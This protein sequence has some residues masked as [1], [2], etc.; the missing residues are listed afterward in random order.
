MRIF[1][2][3]VIF[4]LS[5]VKSQGQ[6]PG[7][8]QRGQDQLPFSVSGQIVDAETGAPLEYTTVSLHN[9]SDSSLVTGGITNE[10]GEFKISTR[11]GRFYLQ[12]QFISYRDKML[13][14]IHLN[15]NNPEVQLGNISLEPD[16]ETLSEVVVAG[17]KSQMLMKLDKRV[18][19]VGKDLS[20]AGGN[21]A[22]ILDNIP[23]V[24][25]DVDGNV[26]LR[27]SQNVRILVDGKPSGLVGIS[28]TDALR[29]LQGDLIERIE[30]ITNPSARY[31]AEGMAGIINIILKKDNREGLN[32]AFNI[33]AGYPNNYGA[34]INLNL[35]KKWVNLFVNYGVNYRKTPGK[36]SSFQQ[37]FFSDSTY[38][39]DRTRE[40]ER[41][42]LSNNARFGA[43][44]FLNDKNTLTTSM[45]YRVSDE[46]N[47][48]DI[49]YK[50]FSGAG[51][52]IAQTLRQDKEI[53]DESNQ[54]YVINYSR[55]F[56]KKRQKLTA[57]IQY[58][59]SRE[60]EDSDLMESLLDQSTVSFE[61]NLFQ[62]SLNDELENNLFIQADYVHPFGKEGKIETGFRST[63]R[64][65]D[66]DYI[67]EE[68]NESG[69]WENLEGFT[70]HFNYDENIYAVYAI[71]GNKM[72]RISYQLG[73]RM[74][75]TDIRTKLEETNED[76]EKNYTDF[77]PSAHLTYELKKSNSIQASY[78]RR[79]NRPRFR[80]L[81]PFS[82]FSDSRNI[83]TGNPDL[84]PEY[85]NSY[86]IGYLKNWE[87]ASLYYGVYYRHTTDVTQR[88]TRVEDGITFTRPENLSTENAFG[89]EANISKDIKDWW[90]VN[91]NVNLYRA[92]IDGAAFGEDLSSDTYSMSGRVNSKMTFWKALDYQLSMMYRAPREST[93]GKRKAMYSVDMGLSK[94]ILKN[95]GTISLS[96][97][98]L[99]N[100]RKWRSET[101]G[102]NFFS[103][104]E[105][106]WRSRQVLVSFSYRL[107]QRKKRERPDRNGYENGD[108][109][110]F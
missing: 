42:G 48:T 6:Q 78:S 74:E 5:I 36:G 20:N 93:Q 11:P 29:Q 85:T 22:E 109:M 67:V 56:D 41:G 107:N 9:I 57:D 19:N 66:N 104:S 94:D 110:E 99:F 101:F 97:R 16:S 84:D 71:A 106:Q 14:N 32:G 7:F 61:A 69:V 77:F 83:W 73:L 39:T 46:E 95:K 65:I 59:E 89:I 63:F 33:T 62:R 92:M 54:E 100:T 50:D 103:D 70:N 91:G 60:K 86:E 98:D 44:F 52:L 51:N 38:F 43:D 105:F 3:I 1:L 45:L 18:F 26:S 8:N 102:A 68:L 47:D 34:S 27:G 31:E 76:N 37:F 25:V 13:E 49:R 40:H 55:T 88:I 108:D 64:K 4:F 35:R 2:S 15:K 79:L 17:E 24:T 21:A 10:K 23:S 96:V 90:K 80:E 72:N 82:S 53:E 12:V 28:S 81:N 58:R 30:V 75:I 87:D